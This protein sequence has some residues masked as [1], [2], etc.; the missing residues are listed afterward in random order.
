M[1]PGVT[2]EDF[3]EVIGLFSKTDWTQIAKGKTIHVGET[4]WASAG[5]HR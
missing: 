5:R 3:V 1:R 4:K 2:E